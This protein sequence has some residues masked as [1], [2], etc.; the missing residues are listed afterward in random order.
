[1]CEDHA[2]GLSNSLLGGLRRVIGNGVV[3]R[4]QAADLLAAARSHAAAHGR[5]KACAP[6]F[7]AAFESVVRGNGAKPAS[8]SIGAQSHSGPNCF[9]CD[10]ATEA[11]VLCPVHSSHLALEFV[12]ALRRVFSGRS[13]DR[14]Q[15][16]ALLACAGEPSPK[17][18]CD[19]EHCLLFGAAREELETPT[20]I[21]LTNG[22]LANADW[23]QL[24]SACELANL[25]ND[26]EVWLDDDEISSA[27]QMTA[28]EIFEGCGFTNRFQ[29]ISLQISYK[30]RQWQ[31]EEQEK[32]EKR[33]YEEEDL[34]YAGKMRDERIAAV[35]GLSIGAIVALGFR[36]RDDLIRALRLRSLPVPADLAEPLD[37]VIS[38]E[39]L[40]GWQNE[41][42]EPL[43]TPPRQAPEPPA[44]SAA[45]EVSDPPRLPPQTASEVPALHGFQWRDV[46]FGFVIALFPGGFLMGAFLHMALP[47]LP[48]WLYVIAITALLCVVVTRR[49]RN[50]SQPRATGN[51][52]ARAIAPA[53]VTKGERIRVAAELRLREIYD[54]HQKTKASEQRRLA[55]SVVPELRELR[56]LAPRRFED[57]VAGMYKRL[58]Y[59]VTQTPYSNDEGRD[60]ILEKDGA[61]FLVECKRYGSTNAVGRP[62]VQKFHSAV[63]VANARKGFI[64][65]TGQFTDE[66]REYV[67][68]K[69]L[70]IVLVDDRALGKLMYSSKAAASD[71]DS[72][73]TVCLDCGGAARHSLRAPKVALCSGGHS[74]SPS[75]VLEDVLVMSGCAPVCKQCGATMR[76]REGRRGRFWGCARYPRCL[77]TEPFR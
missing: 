67:E 63:M 43:A 18:G 44:P 13:F 72:Y 26:A 60:A 40:W 36:S 10:A 65:T 66:A 77:R 56:R 73:E 55:R 2:R 35:M 6:D 54:A 53:A 68:S 49:E 69:S 29:Y 32:R 62:E 21:Q 8:D 30:Q 71:D 42:T 24:P 64:V 34:E 11:G 25:S 48:F 7:D 75:V 50:E 38:A 46:V 70:P 58:G 23:W 16:T 22:V 20:D 4:A 33:E 45:P 59:A 74:V 52:E 17:D 15:V 51:A 9:I 5:R 1:M 12:S 19:W 27:L 14:S 61:I 57:A 41:L 76:V 3:N 28:S 47:E 31:E 39:R 37:A